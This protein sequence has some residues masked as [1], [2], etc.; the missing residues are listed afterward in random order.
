M[1][2]LSPTSKAIFHLWFHMDH[3]ILPGSWLAEREQELS[4]RPRH[5]RAGCAF[6]AI[7]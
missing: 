2:I 5:S 7:S 3:V 4:V 1:M 6:F